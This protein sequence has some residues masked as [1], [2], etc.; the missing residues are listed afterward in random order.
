MLTTILILAASFAAPD[1]VAVQPAT[2]QVQPAWHVPG[3]PPPAPRKK[4]DSPPV[5][6][7]KPLPPV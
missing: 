5:L 7:D 2:P 6:R 4:N 1:A 3:T